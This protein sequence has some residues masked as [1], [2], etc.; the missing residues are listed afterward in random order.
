MISGGSFNGLFMGIPLLVA[1]LSD[2]EESSDAAILHPETRREDYMETLHGV[3]VAD[4]YRWLEDGTSPEVREW[5]GKQNDFARNYFES[6]SDRKKLSTR[7]EEILKVEYTDI[8]TK[9]AGR[10][11]YKKRKLGQELFSICMKEGDDGEEIVLIDPHSMSEKHTSNVIILDITPDG[12]LM[13]YG[14]REGGEDE[15]TIR[16]FDIDGRKDLSDE[17][18]RERYYGVSVRHDKT[19][20]YYSK[21]S[22]NDKA[23]CFHTMGSDNSEDKVLYGGISEKDRIIGSTL[24]EDGRYLIIH[25]LHGSSGDKTEVYLMDVNGTGELVTIVNDVDAYFSATM[26][27]N[28]LILLTTWDAPNKRVLTVDLT[29]PQKEN[30]KEIIPETDGVIEFIQPAGGKLV[31]NYLKNVRFNLKIYNPDGTFVYDIPLPDMGTVTEVTGD[32]SDREVFFAFESFHIPDTVYKFNIDTKVVNVWMEITVPVDSSKFKI[33][34][35]W[36]KSTDK[37][38]VPM[39]IV[40]K[41]GTRKVGSNPTLLTAYG[42]FNLSVTPSF[43]AKH[44]VWLEN[45]GV[46]AIPNIRG[47]GEFGDKWH[48]AG[49]KL[50]KQNTF[51]DF[52]AAAEF[53]IEHGWTSPD[54]LVI[55]G[56]SNGGLLVGA[57]MLQRPELFGAVVCS[58]PLLDM[59]RFHKFLVGMY[60]VSEYGSP[61]DPEHFRNL[62]SYSPYH[63]V[64]QGEKY[65]PVLFITGD[66]DTRVAPLH[67]R[68]M[69]A[70]MQA[71]TGSGKPVLLHYDVKNGH[72]GNKA[73]RKIVDDIADELSF[74]LKETGA[75]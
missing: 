1:N 21:N 74:M 9:K 30:W 43:R 14:V 40:T 36:F 13:A 10:Y 29:S 38:K 16:V 4:P 47:G 19:G 62:L 58:Y 71:A 3:E 42:G 6:I 17:L 26:A 33:R 24:S 70:L 72:V 54:K 52:I 63:N 39:F 5:I 11:F 73:V 57:A 46:L 35:V 41:R 65:P 51:D 60:W 32:W 8:P 75:F 23:V 7:L 68:K 34:Q 48:R 69:A 18:P 28:R 67:A 61:D 12:K 49:M 56:G 27:G 37:V 20:I 31:V 50:N 15:F 45:G 22:F 55:S 25:V 2:S 66:A 59:L 64:K 44:I 53:L